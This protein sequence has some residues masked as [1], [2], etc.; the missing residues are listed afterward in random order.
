VTLLLENLK[1]AL[2]ELR[3]NPFRSA[4]TTLGIVIAVTAVVAVVSIV[5]GAS[6][7]MLQQFEGLGANVIWCFP[8]RPPGVEGR[9]LSKIE[10]TYQDA[11]AVARRCTAL[12]AL[13]P[14][15]QRS[16]IVQLDGQETTCEVLGT[17]PDY[18]R[19]RN[20]APDGGRFFLPAEVDEAANLCVVGQEVLKKLKSTRERATGRTLRVAGRTL[21]VIGFM[22]PKGAI[23]GR[24]Q[25]EVIIVPITT[26]QRMFGDWALRRL[27]ITAQAKDPQQSQAAI[28]QIRWTLR[29]RHGLRGEQPDD[30]G[31]FTQDEFLASFQRVSVMVTGLLI[32]IVS[33]ALLV[34]GIG[35]M[36]IMLVSVS[37]RTR[38]IGIRKAIGA[39]NRDILAQFL[40]E[41][42]TLGLL[43]GVAGI[44]L[45]VLSG[46]LARE[47]IAVFV[48]FP[49]VHVPL[50][51]V[52]L[53]F[54]FA[55]S[56]GLISG[57]YPAWKAARLDP[58]EALRHD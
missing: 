58:I 47:A 55:G 5:Q 43:G 11:Q 24:S 32:G 39:K 28:D 12:A 6:R 57:M 19:T 26:A 21:R 46:L 40:I 33:V 50:W 31:I 37:E 56:V 20:W 48:D 7:F 38:E 52:G 45:G 41:A 53:A 54:G 14:V 17:T 9:R 42:I 51:A 49:P 4:L 36:N 27:L 35:I 13:A 44:A 30:F 29:L 2:A 23:M 34:G 16:G 10:L 15:V 18:Q 8:Q 1:I 22:E 3:A 25:D